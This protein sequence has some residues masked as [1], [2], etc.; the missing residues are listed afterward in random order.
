MLVQDNQSPLFHAV[1]EGREDTMKQL[2]D[3]NAD[4]NLQDYVSRIAEYIT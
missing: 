1:L 2:L 3:A 4:V